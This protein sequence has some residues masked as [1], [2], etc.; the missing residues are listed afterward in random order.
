MSLGHLRVPC[1]TITT[2]L[3]TSASGCTGRSLSRK[4]NDR[5]EHIALAGTLPKAQT[6]A[7]SVFIDEVDAELFKCSPYCANGIVGDLSP[8]SLKI[9]NRRKPQA[10]SVRKLGLSQI[11]QCSSSSALSWR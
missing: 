1:L 9:H 2:S 5:L 11:K 6:H 8:R 4:R 10:R 7:A 3:G